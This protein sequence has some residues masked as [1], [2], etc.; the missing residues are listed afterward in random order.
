[1][2]WEIGWNI[3]GERKSN[4]HMLDIVPSALYTSKPRSNALR[5]T[6]LFQVFFYYL[7][8][9]T[10]ALHCS[11]WTFSSCSKRGLLSGF[12][13]D[14]SCFRAWSLEHEVF[15]SRGAQV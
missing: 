12:G 2:N 14:F 10:R 8:L 13:T 9:S 1:M 15:S 4:D 6:E 5:Q 11:V 7:F 3:R